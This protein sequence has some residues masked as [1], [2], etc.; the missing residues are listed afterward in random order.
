MKTRIVMI[1]LAALTLGSATVLSDQ[2]ISLRLTMTVAP[3]PP[4]C[5]LVVELFD[6][7]GYLLERSEPACPDRDP[8]L[9]AVGPGN[10]CRI[11]RIADRSVDGAGKRS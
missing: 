8:C 4:E 1:L 7:E 2:T 3:K 5:R 11:E 9:K 10:Q 6:E